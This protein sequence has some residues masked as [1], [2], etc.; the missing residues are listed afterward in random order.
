[1]IVGYGSESL[2]E[3]F[4]PFLEKKTKKDNEAR[5]EYVTFLVVLDV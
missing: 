5:K 1:M 2:E 4:W 3:I